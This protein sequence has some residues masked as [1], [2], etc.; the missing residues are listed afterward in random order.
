MS[1]EWA[2][3]HCQAPLQS[4][5]Q[6]QLLHAFAPDQR[7]Q[8]P[9]AIPALTPLAGVTPPPSHSLSDSPEELPVTAAPASGDQAASLG[10]PVAAADAA[11][12]APSPV[13]PDR[14]DDSGSDG[15]LGLLFVFD[16][17]PYWLRSAA[18]T[19]IALPDTVAGACLQTLFRKRLPQTSALLQSQHVRALAS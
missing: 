12:P 10:A 6:Q 4:P 2:A 11:T 3:A 8:T 17:R 7:D 5:P 14:I 1:G 19:G 16:G 15:R 13:Q 18:I 9:G